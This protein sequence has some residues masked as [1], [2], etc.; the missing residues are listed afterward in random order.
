MDG[1]KDKQQQPPE[2]TEMRAVSCL[3]IRQICTTKQIPVYALANL[4]SLCYLGVLVVEGL[5]FF[6]TYLNTSL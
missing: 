1:N 2:K 6:Y 4:F 3:G 5:R